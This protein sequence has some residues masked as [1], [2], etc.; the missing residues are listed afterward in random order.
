MRKPSHACQAVLPL[1]M[2]AL[3]AGLAQAKTASLSQTRY[4]AN[5]KQAMTRCKED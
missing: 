4:A 2:G 1:V 3:I 5:S